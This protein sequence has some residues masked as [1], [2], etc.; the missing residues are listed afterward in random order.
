MRKI[1]W[2]IREMRKQLFPYHHEH[3]VERESERWDVE[4][5][6]YVASWL[7]QQLRVCHAKSRCQK[8]GKC[9]F[10]DYGDL[11]KRNFEICNEV[12]L[13]LENGDIRCSLD[14]DDGNP[15]D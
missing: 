10:F 4:E 13:R 12:Q 2:L 9:V 11:A 14:Y 8:R 7:L 15:L 1:E 6:E 3:D 5:G